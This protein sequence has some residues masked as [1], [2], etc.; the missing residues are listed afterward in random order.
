MSRDISGIYNGY[1][2]VKHSCA[3][4]DDKGKSTCEA[5]TM[6]FKAAYKTYQE[7]LNNP[8]ISDKRTGVQFFAQ[9]DNYNPCKVAEETL[10]K[11]EDA[12]TGAVMI[13]IDEKKEKE[14]RM[15]YNLFNVAN[16]M[17]NAEKQA[18]ADYNQNTK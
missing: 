13:T 9:N 18:I 6:I 3:D 15:I 7:D 11:I 2:K 5:Q 14:C 10:G 17:C 4:K 12:C 16:K 1:Y 8:N